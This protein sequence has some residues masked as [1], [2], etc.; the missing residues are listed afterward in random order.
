[1]ES[2]WET[3]WKEWRKKDVKS[4]EDLYFQVGKTI[5]SKPIGREVF[6]AMTRDIVDT[7]LLNDQDILVELCCGNGLCTYELKDSVKQIIAVDFSP[8]L[9]EAAREFKSAPQITYNFGDV[10]SFLT[11][12]RTKWT[13]E[14]HKYLMN[15]SLAYFDEEGLRNILTSMNTIS[16]GGFSFLIKG[17]PND[18]RKWNYYDTEARKK[19]YFDD[20]AA[21]D[22]TNDGMGKWWSPAAIKKVCDEVGLA[23]I[24]RDQ[25]PPISHYRMDILIS[26]K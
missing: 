23:C 9:I 8:H 25:L 12:F 24:I 10:F 6:D 13:V 17:A 11:D 15:D 19:K 1:M 7:L 22:T 16:P 4:E 14:P 26:K 3:F 2:N 20:I 5:H 21:G 18:D